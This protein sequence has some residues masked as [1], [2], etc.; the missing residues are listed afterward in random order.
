MIKFVAVIGSLI[1][2]ILPGPL[3]VAMGAGEPEA[4]RV[5]RGLLSVNLDRS[6]AGQVFQ[7]ISEKAKIVIRVDAT[8]VD[9]PLTEQFEKV[10]LEEG[11]Q[12][13]SSSFQS[14]N[15]AIGYVADPTGGRRVVSLDILVPGG[16]GKVW[17]FGTGAAGGGTD[18]QMIPKGLQKKMV[19]ALNPGLKKRFERTG[20][21]ETEIPEG[22]QLKK[23]RGERMPGA[24]PWKYDL[25]LN[26]REISKASVDPQNKAPSP[27]IPPDSG[28]SKP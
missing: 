6:P 3:D 20:A 19:R 4:V 18:E 26:N 23:E 28:G 8:L 16:Q 15:F 5:E 13:L 1:L 12:R 9:F 2:L 24:W 17:E 21:L 14:Q 27:E 11:L 7:E 10:S 25:R 22:M